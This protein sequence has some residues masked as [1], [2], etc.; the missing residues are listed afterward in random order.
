MV[1]EAY[2]QDIQPIHELG[3]HAHSEQEQQQG[4]STC[5]Q[6]TLIIYY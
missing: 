5:L 1:Q 3:K 6:E 4:L 2:A